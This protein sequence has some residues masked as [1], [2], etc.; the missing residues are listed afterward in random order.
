MYGWLW[1]RLPGGTVV[2][3]GAMTVLVLA[4]AAALWFV[5]FPW[6]ASYLPIDG[7]AFT[8]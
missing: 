6:V 2:R 4:V 5:V 1:Q 3:A 8:G 7:T